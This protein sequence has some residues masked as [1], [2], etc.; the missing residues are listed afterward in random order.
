LLIGHFERSIFLL[1]A[2]LACLVLASDVQETSE[3]DKPLAIADSLFAENDYAMSAE[4]YKKATDIDSANFD[5]FWKLGR[6][7]NLI[8]ETS[9]R[10]SQ[11]AIFERARDAESRA[12]AIDDGSA[13]AHFQMARALGKIALFKG[14]FKSVGLAKRVK[15]EAEMALAI[16]SLHDG[17]WHILGRWHREIGKKPKLLRGPLGLGEANREDAVKFMRRAIS[18]NPKVINHHLE[19]GITYR[20]YGK[21]DLAR[22]EFQE[23]LALPGRTPLDNKYKEEAK[24]YLAVME[25]K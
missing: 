24:N 14:V 10:D 9:A 12:L 2:A 18:L 8:G 5:G 17:A 3:Q 16:D 13:D 15:R 21:T 22:T 7:L 4:Y 19:M 1:S 23:C 6:S 20:E 11:L 25:G